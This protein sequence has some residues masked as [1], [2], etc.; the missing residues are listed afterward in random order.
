MEAAKEEDDAPPV[1]SG[2]GSAAAAAAAA[3]A[4]AVAGVDDD[5]APIRQHVTFA[6]PLVRQMS[7]QSTRPDYFRNLRK[8]SITNLRLEGRDDDMN[9]DVNR[10]ERRDSRQ[11]ETV[12]DMD[13]AVAELRRRLS[14]RWTGN[15]GGD[16]MSSKDVPVEV[17]LKDFSYHVPIRVD[18]P[19]IDTALNTS[20]CYVATNIMKNFGEYITGKRR[21]RAISTFL[22]LRSDSF[23]VAPLTY[24]MC[25]R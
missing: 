13:V 9:D 21:V 12:V 16:G 24:A 3:A 1:G 15:D 19:S 25:V 2:E 18:G 14:A 10:Q 22:L 20:P 7:V 5:D 6:D 4:V 23:L 11:S 8:G 17:R